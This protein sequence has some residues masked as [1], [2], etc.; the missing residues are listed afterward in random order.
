[1]SWRVEIAKPEDAF[2]LDALWSRVY[3]SNEDAPQH[4]QREWPASQLRTIIRDKG[5]IVAAAVTHPFECMRGKDTLKCA[6][7]AS[8]ATGLEARQTGAA[9][10]LTAG[11]LKEMHREGYA[12]SSLYAYK[13]NFYRKQGYE[14]CGARYR[15]VSPVCD[16][17][18][19]SERIPIEVV[20]HDDVQSM[21]SVYEQFARSFNG[22]FVRDEYLWKR[23]IGKRAQA[24]YAIGSPAKA[25]FWANVD[26][27]WTD[28]TIGECA[29]TDPESYRALLCAFRSLAANHKT[30]TWHEPL[31]SAFV[32]AFGDAKATYNLDRWTMYRIINIEKAF[33]ACSTDHEGSF[34]IA[35]T[36]DQIPENNGSFQITASGGKITV[37]RLAS[38][39]QADLTTTIGH[40]SQ[41]F[42]GHPGTAELVALGY[43]QVDN[44]QALSSAMA[45]M[46]SRGVT[47]MDFF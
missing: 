17:P 33:T 27:F 22:S 32:A 36:D 28:L 11:T 47:C 19:S 15:I 24:I 44:A 29:Y 18:T 2:E 21:N 31:N 45:I 23:R 9:S 26:N 35:V 41:A 37:E 13:D 1:M 34:S 5:K 42:M 10:A 43:I 6:G 25:Y 46:P 4:H 40:L 14:I 3:V 7:L 8:V 16:L 30:V 39:K 12:I 38:G 20:P